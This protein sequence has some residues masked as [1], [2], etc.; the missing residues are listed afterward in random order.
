MLPLSSLSKKKIIC[1]FIRTF[2]WDAVHPCNN[3]RGCKTARVQSWRSDE[4][5]CWATKRQFFLSQTFFFDIYCQT[6]IFAKLISFL[7][8][9]TYLVGLQIYTLS[10]ATN[11]FLF[12]WFLFF[13]AIIQFVS[14]PSN[15]ACSNFH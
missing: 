8:K 6:F 5:A 1:S 13:V 7:M 4:I 15:V 11:I 9:I 3:S 12:I 10:L 14:R 2:K